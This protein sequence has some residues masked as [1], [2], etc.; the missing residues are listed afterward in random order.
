MEPVK[1]QLYDSIFSHCDTMGNGHAYLKDVWDQSGFVFS[2]AGAESHDIAVYTEYDLWRVIAHRRSGK[3]KKYFA[4]LMESPEVTKKFYTDVVLYAEHFDAV[5]TFSDTLLSKIDNGHKY[6]LGGSWLPVDSFVSWDQKT[7]DISMV[8]SDKSSLI[9]HKLRHEVYGVW[10]NRIDCWG[11]ITGAHYRDRAECFQQYKFSVVIENCIHETYFSEKL[12]DCCLAGCIPI[13]YGAQ[14]E[15][16]GFYTL[17]CSGYHDINAWIRLVLGG[18]YDAD[19][20]A[21]EAQKNYETAI[22]YSVTE[23]N[24]W[25]AMKEYV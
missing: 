9:G 10:G 11:T 6:H 12:I 15:D 25:E 19:L 17:P 5:F 2:R 20:M 24:L 3:H 22:K 14:V 16:F 4:V 8:A 23:K 18:N 7:A 21:V 1:I 13:Y